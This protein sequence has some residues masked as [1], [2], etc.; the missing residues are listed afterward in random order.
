MCT[1]ARGPSVK[2]V[3]QEAGPGLDQINEEG[4]RLQ[5]M[6]LHEKLSPEHGQDSCLKGIPW[7]KGG[8]TCS[9]VQPMMVETAL[10]GVLANAGYAKPC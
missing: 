10:D 7:L 4:H 2:H 3:R 6:G 9:H 8:A 1:D 5:Q